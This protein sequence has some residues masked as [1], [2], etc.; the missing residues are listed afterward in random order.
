MC[1][2]PLGSTEQA[3]KDG[4]FT[5]LPLFA[6]IFIRTG[7]FS[8]IHGKSK[9]NFWKTVLEKSLIYLE[10][11]DVAVV[12]I[13]NAESSLLSFRCPPTAFMT[14]SNLS[15]RL[16]KGKMRTIVIVPGVVGGSVPDTHKDYREY[17]DVSHSLFCL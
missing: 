3:S 2:F 15:L 12:K 8:N 14:L 6:D 11:Y 5:T 9:E 16:L 7:C 1:W 10:E 4:L 17:K 13:L